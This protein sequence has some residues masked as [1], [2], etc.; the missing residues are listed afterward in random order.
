MTKLVTCANCGYLSRKIGTPQLDYESEDSQGRK[1]TSI[2]YFWEYDE[3]PHYCRAEPEG[4]NELYFGEQPYGRFTYANQVFTLACFRR[5]YNLERE[6]AVEQIQPQERTERYYKVIYK[7]RPCPFWFPHTPG[8]SPAAH[9]Q[10]EERRRGETTN[11]LWN[12][13]T[14]LLSAAVGGGIAI[15]AI[16]L[17]Q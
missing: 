3:I 13:V 16:L 9:L 10:L 1:T 2:K 6:F 12:L 7:E 15:L 14:A 17:T 11:R 8:L 5:A 4:V